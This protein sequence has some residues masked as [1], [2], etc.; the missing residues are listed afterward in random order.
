[1]NH[2]PLLLTLFGLVV[3]SPSAA[4]S[5]AA[6]DEVALLRQ[7]FSR[8]VSDRWVEEPYALL[9]YA[10]AYAQL[11]DIEAASGCLEPQYGAYVDRNA[12]RQ[13]IVVFFFDAASR[14]TFPLAGITFRPVTPSGRATS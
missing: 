6:A 7:V 12:E 10:D 4:E 11:T 9:V 1:M 3:C 8:Q 13:L 2:L 5:D 14:T